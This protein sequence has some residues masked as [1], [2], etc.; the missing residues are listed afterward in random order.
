MS[1]GATS[2]T[3]LL[4]TAQT[5]IWLAQQFHPDSPVDN[6]AQYTVI[7]IVSQ[8]LPSSSILFN[9]FFV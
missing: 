2:V 5:E 7:T 6:I 1:V 4:S 8:N 3:Y 9:C